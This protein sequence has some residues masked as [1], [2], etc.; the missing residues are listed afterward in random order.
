MSRPTKEE[1]A[2]ACASLAAGALEKAALADG[3][4]LA[5]GFVDWFPDA[6]A[7]FSRQE[8]AEI[9]RKHL[10]GHAALVKQRRAKLTNDGRMTVPG[11]R[12]EAS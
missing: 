10:I 2:F 9:V 4:H 7:H 5:Q 6:D 12:E 3:R 11:R 8:M 1:V